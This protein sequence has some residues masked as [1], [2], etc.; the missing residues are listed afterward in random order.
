MVSALTPINLLLRIIPTTEERIRPLLLT[1]L[2]SKSV[3]ANTSKRL[4]TVN[5]AAIQITGV[6]HFFH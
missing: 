4:Q 3:K 2:F 5:P 1:S 6:V